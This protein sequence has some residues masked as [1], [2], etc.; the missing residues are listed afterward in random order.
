MA[1]PS[2]SVRTHPLD[3]WSFTT[4]NDASEGSGDRPPIVDGPVG[5]TIVRDGRELVN[6]AS[7]NFLDLQHS[8]P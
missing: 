5:P 1:L 8:A 7:I 4:F 3:A 6:F 2:E